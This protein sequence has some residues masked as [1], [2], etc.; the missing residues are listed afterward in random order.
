MLRLPDQVP[1]GIKLRVLLLVDDAMI[2]V[3]MMARKIEEGHSRFFAATFAYTRAQAAR[4]VASTYSFA[5]WI[6]PP[7]GPKTRVGTPP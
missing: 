3:E 4:E 5:W 2:A 1:N 7:S 6:P